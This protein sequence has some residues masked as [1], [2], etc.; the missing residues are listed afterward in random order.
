MSMKYI[1][2][3]KVIYSDT[4]IP[5]NN[6]LNTRNSRGQI[7]SIMEENGINI[8]PS[9]GHGSYGYGESERV[10]KSRTKIKLIK[11]TPTNQQRV[12]FE[13][14]SESY[15]SSTKKQILEDLIQM[16]VFGA[17]RFGVVTE[18]IN[19]REKYWLGMQGATLR[20]DDI[21][22]L[23]D[24]AN[25]LCDELHLIP[26]DMPNEEA[27][28]IKCKVEDKRLG[29]GGRPR[30]NALAFTVEWDS[31]TIQRKDEIEK[32]LVQ[33]PLSI[34]AHFQA[35]FENTLILS[36][37]KRSHGEK[38]TSEFFEN[39]EIDCHFDAISESRSECTPD[40][41]KQVRDAKNAKKMEMMD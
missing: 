40:I 8:Q 1:R 33:Y 38:Y 9:Y 10:A 23:D 25:Y 2:T 4:V 31:K 30:Y 37:M 11:Y 27:I 16:R 15:T 29:D 18:E 32:W 39:V 6:T 3:Y 22:F 12:K 5:L 24:G 19:E 13:T 7:C 17:G 28:V 14:D 35:L 26:N 41:I 36:D 21:D 20:L 34:I